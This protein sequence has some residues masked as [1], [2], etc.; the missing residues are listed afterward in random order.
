MDT[1]EKTLFQ[2]IPSN[3]LISRYGA[4]YQ[5]QDVVDCGD[6]SFG[7]A[8]PGEALFSLC[9]YQKLVGEFSHFLQGSLAGN[10]AGIL[11][12]FLDPQLSK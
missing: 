6:F 2:E 7:R 10:L 5:K 1:F 9:T 12:I 3:S 11:R 8:L 4:R